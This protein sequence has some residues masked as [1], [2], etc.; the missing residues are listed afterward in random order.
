[1]GMALNRF[2]MFCQLRED[3][4]R[5]DAFCKFVL[6]AVIVHDNNDQALIN[7]IK[8]NFIDW[9]E[10]TGEKWPFAGQAAALHAL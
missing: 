1:M 7:K 2:D 3:M 6:S 9:A 8:A 5:N 10:L 4:Q